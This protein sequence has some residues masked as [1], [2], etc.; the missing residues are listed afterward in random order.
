[1][2][3]HRHADHKSMLDATHD[4][5]QMGALAIAMSLASTSD[6]GEVDVPPELPPDIDIDP[7]WQP[8]DG[9]P[10]WAGGP[11]GPPED[12]EEEPLVEEEDDEDADE[13]EEEEGG[14]AAKSKK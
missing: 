5:V 4:Q 8:G 10:P 13:I 1:M 7:P 3:F 12:P 11:G 2:A 6:D 14:A 9:K